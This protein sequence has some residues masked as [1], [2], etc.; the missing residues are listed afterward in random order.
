MIS[1]TQRPSSAL[2]I[3]AINGATLSASLRTGT[4]META[5]AAWSEQGKSALLAWVSIVAGT[6]RAGGHGDRFLWGESAPGNPFEAS[7]RG[8]G[9]RHNGTVLM[10]RKAEPAGGKPVAHDHRA[11]D[12]DE[13]AGDDVAGMM[14]QQHQ[15]RRRNHKRVNG[16]R[17]PSARPDRGHR[18]RQREAGDGMARR[19]TGVGFG[20]GKVRKVEGVGLAADKGPAAADDP[21]DHFAGENGNQH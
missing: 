19:K 4:T 13:R 7:G 6:V 20:A 16:H 5:T 14:G 15:A 9:Q 10:D 3:S 2:A 8:S 18:K 21:F 17:D 11:D 1:Y 12:A